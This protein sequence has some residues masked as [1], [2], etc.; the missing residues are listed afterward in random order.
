MCHLVDKRVGMV[1]KIGGQ[2]C[3]TRARYCAPQNKELK[4]GSG[5]LALGI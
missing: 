4:Q 3:I 5:H 1:V 2:L